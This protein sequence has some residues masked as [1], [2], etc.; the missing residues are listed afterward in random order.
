MSPAHHFPVFVLGSKRSGTTAMAGVV[1]DCL[2]YRGD[3]EGNI[4]PI[5][6][7]AHVYMHALATME[8]GADSPSFQAFSVGRIGQDSVIDALSGLLDERCRSL[9]Q[10][11][12]WY[13]KTPGPRMVQAVPF[14]ARYFHRAAFIFLKRSGIDAVMSMQRKW[15]ASA[16]SEQCREWTDTMAA[17]LEVRDA[18]AD[19]A[20]EVEQLDMVTRSDEVGRQVADLL[21]VDGE[22]AAAIGE[23][24]RSR[25]YEQ[26]AVQQRPR[27]LS[28]DETGW[29][30]T[31]QRIFQHVCWPMMQ[32]FGYD[33]AVTEEP[34]SGP[35]PVVLTQALVMDEAHKTIT[36]DGWNER[37]HFT[38]EGAFVVFED[39]MPVLPA[40]TF[41]DIDRPAPFTCFR[42]EAQLFFAKDAAAAS[43]VV[44]RVAIHDAAGARRASQDHILRMDE[45]TAIETRFAPLEGPVSVALSLRHPAEPNPGN[46]G[47]LDIRWPRLC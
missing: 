3:P 1:R 30:E 38:D 15:P 11:R 18:I 10:T 9:H 7:C 22:R 44:L 26:T 16:F 24:L 19:R 37:S 43:S 2:G 31:Q 8:G 40:F 21:Q 17:W 33:A 14:V 27:Y 46:N 39:S 34:P 13:D 12:V 5:V 6:H 45:F 42:C 25:R 35:L 28:L 4:W 32:A 23:F 36:T 47:G 20:I 41:H 29:P